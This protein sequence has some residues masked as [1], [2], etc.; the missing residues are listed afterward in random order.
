MATFFLGS[1][2][3]GPEEDKRLTDDVLLPSLMLTWLHEKP[4]KY[5]NGDILFR[6]RR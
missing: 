3:D 4:G 2:E 5:N 6:Y 1:Q